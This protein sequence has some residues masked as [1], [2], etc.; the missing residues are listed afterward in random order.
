MNEELKEAIAAI[1]RV[2]EA[3]FDLEVIQKNL[4][5]LAANLAVKLDTLQQQI[6][7][8]DNTEE[9]VDFEK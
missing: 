5:L 3:A 1:D 9:A 8:R 6:W 7:E 2:Y 4:Q